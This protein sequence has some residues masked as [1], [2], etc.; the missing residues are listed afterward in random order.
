MMMAVL[1]FF[2]I[3]ITYGS[4]D[5][6]K[7]QKCDVDSVAEYYDKAQHYDV[8]WGKDNIHTGFYPH[9]T[10]RMEVPLNV[11][12]AAQV[13]TRRLLTLG[14]V[15]HT[16]TVLDL[17]CGKGL[18]CKLV[19]ELT[20]AACT[21][22]DLSEGNIA[23]AKELARQHPDLNLDFL[24]GSF[25]DMPASLY[26]RF[27]HVIAQE[28]LVYAHAQLPTVL[29]ELHKVL[30]K[31]GVALV[32]DFLGAD[33]PVSEQTKKAVHERLGFHVL[34]GHMAWRRAVDESRFV[35]RHYENIDRHMAHA[36]RQ[37]AETATQHD[38]R[39]ADGTP[40]ARNYAATSRAAAAGQIG[41]NIALLAKIEREGDE[42]TRAV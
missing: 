15:S 14:D 18:A 28:S 23:R 5:S 10:S 41:K 30:V 11:S 27:T 16:S 32:N 13:S 26:G 24:V 4:D 22:L 21:G 6:N 1:V 33:G 20:G 7:A 35:L 39:S 3:P 31:D 25:T 40:L 19:A 34:L 42:F 37:L 29:D 9:L 17:G 8:L 38:F 2:V 12:Q 36:Y